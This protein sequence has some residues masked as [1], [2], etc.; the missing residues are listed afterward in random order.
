M[1]ISL[2]EPSPGDAPAD[3][4]ADSPVPRPGDRRHDIEPVRP[5]V[6]TRPV[7]P[8]PSAVLHLDPEAVPA[9]LGAHVNAPAI[10]R[11]QTPES[12]LLRQASRISPRRD[13]AL[14][15]RLFPGQPPPLRRLDRAPGS[16]ADPL[17]SPAVLPAALEHPGQN[18]QPRRLPVA[19]RQ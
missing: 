11:A 15:G 13:T 12:R 2:A 9:D 17:P 18:G 1:R 5:P 16:R 4:P 8:R 3:V 10:P 19:R 6:V 7:T 14:P